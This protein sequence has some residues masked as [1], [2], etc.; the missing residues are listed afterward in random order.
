MASISA[1][2]LNDTD[3]SYLNDDSLVVECN[4]LNV[5]ESVVGSGDLVVDE[6]VVGSEDLVVDESVVASNNLDAENQ[7][8]DS[9]NGSGDVV[10][11]PKALNFTDLRSI[12]NN[13]PTDLTLV[14]N[15]DL[16]F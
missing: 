15:Y 8:A 3:S 13:A 12:I 2:E 11:T 1:V 6:S 5:E 4:T 7:V 14:L 16:F 9:E 10:S